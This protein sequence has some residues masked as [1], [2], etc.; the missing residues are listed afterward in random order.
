M[1]ALGEGSSRFF[2]VSILISWILPVVI[3]T[4]TKLSYR[5]ILTTFTPLEVDIIYLF[6]ILCWMY[7][8]LHY[9]N[10]KKIFVTFKF[11]HCPYENRTSLLACI[12]VLLIILWAWAIILY[13]TI[14]HQI[15]KEF[16][17]EICPV[18]VQEQQKD[19]HCVNQKQKGI[20]LDE[21]LKHSCINNSWK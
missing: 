7:P 19:Q 2:L 5:S 10:F 11:S 21:R 3:R 14:S 1:P 13:I 15:F 8:T 20:K 9:F 16:Q 6:I 12:C 4:S 18:Q 17:N